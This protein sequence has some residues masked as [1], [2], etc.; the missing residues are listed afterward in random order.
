[1]PGAGMAIWAHVGWA[2][3]L[4]AA[5]AGARVKHMRAWLGAA[6]AAF[7]LGAALAGDWVVLAWAAVVALACL[8]RI[9][10]PLLG[11]AAVRLTDEERALADA[12]PGLGRTE[13]RHLIDQGLWLD[14]KPGDVLTRAGEPVEQLY[15]IG[16]GGASVATGDRLVAECAAGSFVGEVTVL[17]GAPAT[18][19][20]TVDRPSR[21]WCVP[22]AALR[23]YAL[24][25]DD[26]RRALET[27]FREAL[28]AKLVATNARVA[29]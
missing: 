21:L 26:V 1:M 16:R 3:L 10:G 7:A 17:S 8:V 19:T 5:L 14:A 13:A 11:G 28:I 18:G 25:H 2:L 20:V 27:A 22:A 15:W 24:E 29:G 4:I 6:A 9:A 12:L 23:A